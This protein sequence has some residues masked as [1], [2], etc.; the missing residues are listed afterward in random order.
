MMVLIVGRHHLRGMDQELKDFG[1]K[2]LV[3]WTGL[4]AHHLGASIPEDTDA[5]I[6]LT[7]AISHDVLTSIKQQ[8]QR[9]GIPVLYAR[10]SRSSIKRT[11]ARHIEEPPPEN[12]RVDDGI[13][14][15]VRSPNSGGLSCVTCCGLAF[16]VGS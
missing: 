1:V 8:A 12:C 10:G 15:I 14:S 9:R 6:A 4:K 11:V 7:D 5:V 13:E 3:H 2:R 16:R